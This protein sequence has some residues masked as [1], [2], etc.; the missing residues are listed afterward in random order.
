MSVLCKEGYEKDAPTYL[1]YV[2]DAS[3]Y[4]LEPLIWD[5]VL[6]LPNYSEIPEMHDR[7]IVASAVRRRQ[8][9]PTTVLLPADANIRSSGIVPTPW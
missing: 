1:Q 2:K 9:H 5:D 6:Q 3:G 4:R 7:L 8:Q